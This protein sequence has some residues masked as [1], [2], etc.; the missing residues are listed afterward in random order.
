MMNSLILAAL[1]LLLAG[2]TIAQ[3]TD[4]SGYA[5]VD[6]LDVIGADGLSGSLRNSKPFASRQMLPR[7][8]SSARRFGV[9]ATRKAGGSRRL[10]GCS[11]STRT[12]SNGPDGGS[13]REA[14]AH[15]SLKPKPMTSSPHC[16]TDRDPLHRSS[17]RG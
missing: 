6:N 8:G 10:P 17:H 2:A 4:I 11:T 9:C 15:V 12:R 13:E 5:D 3:T 1:T 7:L 14:F 16:D